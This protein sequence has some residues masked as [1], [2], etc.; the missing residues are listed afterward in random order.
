VIAAGVL[1]TSAAHAELPLT[2][3]IAQ[4]RPVIDIRTRYEMVDD[5]RQRYPSPDDS[6][7]EKE[8]KLD[9]ILSTCSCFS[10]VSTD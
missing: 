8:K 3:I 10:C 9:L 1:L 2:G 6:T 5:A 7:A 4:G